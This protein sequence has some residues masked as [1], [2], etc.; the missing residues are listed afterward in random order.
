MIAPHRS[1]PSREWKITRVPAAPIPASPHFWSSPFG[2]RLKPARGFRPY[3][4]TVMASKPHP[5][6]ACAAPSELLTSHIS[7]PIAPGRA[8]DLL[9]NCEIWAT[10]L[11]FQTAKWRGW[12]S[13]WMK[14]KIN[15]QHFHRAVQTTEQR[16]NGPSLHSWVTREAT[17]ISQAVCVS[18][19][20]HV[21]YV[22]GI[23]GRRHDFTTLP[24]LHTLRQD[25]NCTVDMQRRKKSGKNR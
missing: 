3:Q 6:W 20:V 4:T 14:H 18:G 7:K 19:L 11:A 10:L 25:P 17:V 9:G 5:R 15:N 24:G 12:E 16:Q 21:R 23:W 2:P 13:V 1:A 22:T 8:G